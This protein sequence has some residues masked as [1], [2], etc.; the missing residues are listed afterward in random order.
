MEDDDFGLCPHCHKTN[1][2]ISIGPSHW[3][4]C[5]KH[6]TKWC[7]GSNLFSSW[8]SQTEAEQRAKYEAMDF[9]DYKEVTPFFYPAIVR[10]TKHFFARLFYRI[11]GRFARRQEEC[12]F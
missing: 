7:V 2:F 5:D 11:G 10:N 9:G 6:R 12:P 1:G 8:K 3:F 4:F